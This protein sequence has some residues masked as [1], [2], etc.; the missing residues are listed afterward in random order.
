MSSF[1]SYKKER[2]LNN[3][4]ATYHYYNFYHHSGIQVDS[5]VGDK[6]KEQAEQERAPINIDIKGLMP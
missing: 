3:W 6:G 2:L 4:V 5:K 1:T